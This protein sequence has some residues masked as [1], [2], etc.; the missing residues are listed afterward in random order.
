MI[1]PFRPTTNTRAV[2][3]R[4]A[5]IAAEH[6]GFVTVTDLSRALLESFAAA[7]SDLPVTVQLLHRLGTTN[8]RLAQLNHTMQEAI[9]AMATIADLKTAAD[10]LATNEAALATEVG[11]LSVAVGNLVTV[12]GDL[13]ASGGLSV[14]DQAQLD[15]AVQ[16]V[17]DASTD[18]ATQTG[19]LASDETSATGAA[20]PPT[21]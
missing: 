20:T 14:A 15:A 2:L 16:E 18:V 12:V 1:A 3:E 9:T 7:G 4:S 13:R 19:T 11:T 6:G 5:E 8:D 17:T 10:T 21:P